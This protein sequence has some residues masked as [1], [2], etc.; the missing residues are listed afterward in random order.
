MTPGH[1]VS[2]NVGRPRTVE[3]A[4]REDSTAIVKEPVDGRLRVA[5]DHVA[6]DQQADRDNHGGPWQAVYAYASEDIAW[7]A[8]ELGRDDLGAGAFGE[9]LTLAGI[10]PTEAVV[11][12][13]W[14]VGDAE[15]RVTGPRIPCHKLAWRM[16]DPRFGARF[17]AAGRIGA[18][19]A[20]EAPGLVGAGDLVEVVAVPDHGVT[21][22]DV[23][24]AYHRLGP[25]DPDEQRRL[26][27]R[28]VAAPEMHPTAVAFANARL[29]AH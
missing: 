29:G 17:A 15:L 9:N 5:D 27:E 13:R 4:G 11:G 7:W 14:R 22:H 8:D 3:I 25:D 21:V 26:L 23:S 28:I 18:Y 16:G 6:G 1:V 2:V 20:I 24:D 10:D 19:L 12:A